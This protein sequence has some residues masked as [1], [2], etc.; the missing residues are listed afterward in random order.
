M[1]YTITAYTRAR[2][3]ALG[4]S[5]KPSTNKKKKIDVFK[6]GK[7]VGSVGGVRANGTAYMDYPNYKKKKGIEIANKKR[8]AYLARHAKEPKTKA[9]GSRSNSFWADNLLW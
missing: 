8:K 3:R 7:K 2:A 5:V 6:D 4:V 9:D 1:V